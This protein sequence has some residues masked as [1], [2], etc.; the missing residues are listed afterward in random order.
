MPS[1]GRPGR[2]RQR[3]ARLPGRRKRDHGGVETSF[4]GIAELAALAAL[5]DPADPGEPG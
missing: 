1:T 2:V 3:A 5:A 4:L